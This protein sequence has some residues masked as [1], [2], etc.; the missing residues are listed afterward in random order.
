M[1]RA[2]ISRVSG[3]VRAKVLPTPVIVPNVAGD[4]KKLELELAKAVRAP[5]VVSHTLTGITVGLS[6]FAPAALPTTVGIALLCGA[7]LRTI[8]EAF[9]Q[10][11]AEARFLRQTIKSGHGSELEPG[12]IEGITGANGNIGMFGASMY[13][14]AAVAQRL[15]VEPGST[16]LTLPLTPEAFALW[17]AVSVASLA[18]FP[19]S[20]AWRARALMQPTPSRAPIMYAYGGIFLM[21]GA[22]MHAMGDLQS[23]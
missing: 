20:V 22:A 4:R 3:H 1:L 11:S 17:T 12:K 21:L 19:L 2:A 14:I 15:L 16:S 23:L 10:V 5:M 7:Q 9:R 13:G 6:L 8:P 18:A